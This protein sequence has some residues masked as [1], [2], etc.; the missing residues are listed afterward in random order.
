MPIRLE[1]TIPPQI[2]LDLDPRKVRAVLRSA[3]SE[4]AAPTTHPRS[5]VGG[6]PTLA[7]PRGAAE[8]PRKQP[9]DTDMPRVVGIRL[10]T[11]A[12]LSIPLMN[13]LVSAAS[14]RTRSAP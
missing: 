3:G 13:M 5:P 11:Y 7:E 12:Q 6:E 4:I 9:F 1:I 2:A 10:S 8:S 14:V